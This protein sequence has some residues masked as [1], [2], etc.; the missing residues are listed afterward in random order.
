M[1][2]RPFVLTLSGLAIVALG[3]LDARVEPEVSIALFYVF[4]VA[5]AGFW[6]GPIFGVGTALFAGATWTATTPDSSVV[7]EVWNLAVRCAFLVAVVLPVARLAAMLD[8]ERQAARTDPLTGLANRR[9]LVAA[10]EGALLRRRTPLTVVYFDLDDFKG[11]ND[12]D[13]HA[14]GDALLRRVA[15]AL[16]GA[17]RNRD[18][19]ARVGG[20]EFV[21]L[22]DGSD[23]EDAQAVVERALAALRSAEV[24][25]TLSVGIF[26]VADDE[27]DA[28]TVLAGADRLMYES[29]RSG[30]ARVRVRAA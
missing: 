2:S 7:Q 13:G 12:R 4:P 25:T 8:M 23:A 6:A 1:P 16:R 18:V 11:T 9:A 20:D 27:R 10:L 29:K 30:K 19:A 15:T 24:R 28:E 22:L 21:L 14:A 5:V 3:W 26:G 17:C